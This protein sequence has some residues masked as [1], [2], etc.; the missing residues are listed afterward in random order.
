[1]STKELWLSIGC[2]LL[3]QLIVWL[4]YAGMDHIH[5]H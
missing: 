5:L 2:F 3:V 1:M 4:L